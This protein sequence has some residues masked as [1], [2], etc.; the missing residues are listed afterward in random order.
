MHGASIKLSLGAFMRSL[1]AKG[2]TKSWEAH[3]RNQQ[4]GENQS[5]D[6][7]KSERFRQEGN[8]RINNVSP[9]R[10]GLAKITEKDHSSRHFESPD[11]NL[12]IAS[13]TCCID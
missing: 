13:N 9:M 7:G 4:F 12:H 3:E 1:S 2:C 11:T 5:I 8:A 6:I 10:Q